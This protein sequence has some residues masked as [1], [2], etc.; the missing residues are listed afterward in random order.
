MTSM[1]ESTDGVSS[2][3]LVVDDHHHHQQRG[4]GK[5]KSLKGR[6][7]RSAKDVTLSSN[8][9]E[10]TTVGLLDAYMFGSALS[11][12]GHRAD[13]PDGL[14]QSTSQLGQF[15]LHRNILIDSDDTN[16]NNITSVTDDVDTVRKLIK[17]INYLESQKQSLSK[18]LLNLR[19]HMATLNNNNN[20]NNNTINI[21]NNDD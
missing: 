15:D 5:N 6:S 9:Q 21:N 8:N 18:E 4:S 11:L 7:S 14:N 3:F 20:N 1:N 12:G 17:Y 10:N 13:I 19:N 16:Q 2:G